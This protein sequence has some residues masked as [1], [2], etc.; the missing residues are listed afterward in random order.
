M[1]NLNDKIKKDGLEKI[2]QGNDLLIIIEKLRKIF[3]EQDNRNNDKIKR[4]YLRKWL[5]KV[6]RLRDR[7]NKL[8]DAFDEIEKRQLI[9]DVNTIT[10]VEITKRFNDSIP[11][12]RAYDFFK[13]LKNIHKYRKNL[14]DLKYNLI[15]KLI[16]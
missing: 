6:K 16:K 8:K 7:E 13:I 15:R 10:E 9:K 12:A 14:L 5:D 1:N 11:V 2:K 3:E 4:I